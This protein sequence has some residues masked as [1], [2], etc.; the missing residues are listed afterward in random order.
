MRSSFQHLL[1]ML[2]S[3]TLLAAGPPSCKPS[4]SG[5]RTT[6]LGAHI[7]DTASI[8][9]MVQRRWLQAPCIGLVPINSLPAPAFTPWT[10]SQRLLSEAGGAERRRCAQTSCRAAAGSDA[11]S[12]V[13]EIGRRAAARVKGGEPQLADDW[14]EGTSQQRRSPSRPSVGSNGG[15]SSPGSAR[16]NSQRVAERGVSRAAHAAQQS[17]DS[18]G[19]GA[20]GGGDARARRYL[21]K[22]A[23]LK[24]VPED[25]NR[26]ASLGPRCRCSIAK[27]RQR[28]VMPAGLRS[29]SGQA[30]VLA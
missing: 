14:E 15:R 2:R 26:R 13:R 5:A 9:P 4:F 17:L 28:Q 7:T 1:D 25:F 6:V 27:Y 21:D 12:V 19:S 8:V 10:S 3:P 18:S 24:A 11:S 30:R 23:G 22:I 16:N 29:A 20:S